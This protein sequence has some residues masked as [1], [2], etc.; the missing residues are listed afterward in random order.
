M[1]YAGVT[2]AGP[3]NE[4]GVPFYKRELSLRRRKPAGDRGHR[5][6]RARS[7]RHES[8]PT[9]RARARSASSGRARARPRSV[10]EPELRHP[11]E[12]TLVAEPVD[13]R[14]ARRR[15]VERGL[16]RRA[17]E[18]RR[19]AADERVAWTSPWS[20][21]A[22][23]ASSPSSTSSSDDDLEVIELDETDAEF[24]AFDASF[25]LDDAT[26]DEDEPQ[27][28]PDLDAPATT[29][30]TEPAIENEASDASDEGAKKS[31]GLVRSGRGAKV[32]TKRTGPKS[33]RGGG[34]KVVG[35]KIGASQLA[36]AVVTESEGRHQLVALAR[37]P[38]EPG[39]VVDGE[40]RDA[41]ALAQALKSFFAEHKPSAQGRADRRRQQP[42][43]CPH[44][45]HRGDR[46]PGEVRQRGALQGPRGPPGLRP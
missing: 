36:A 33:P 1:P 37:T 30:G 17:A 46:R 32:A 18:D 31:R 4:E 42:H 34:R 26:A 20:T 6:G 39:I 27:I 5:V 24:A 14:E 23:Q 7:G 43:R 9:T 2:D 40:V 41:D 45:R 11:D 28:A 35:L 15:R 10:D 16:G 44:V 13:G 22:E 12:E 21:V 3:S 8:L 38:L 29:D 19:V 25:P